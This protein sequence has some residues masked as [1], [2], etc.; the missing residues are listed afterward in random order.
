MPNGRRP[1]ERFRNK[2]FDGVRNTATAE[3]GNPIAKTPRHVQAPV[4]PHRPNADIPGNVQKENIEA[5]ENTP[6]L[7]LSPA[8]LLRRQK[9]CGIEAMLRSA[10]KNMVG[11]Q[12][13]GEQRDRSM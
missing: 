6:N 12:I 4:T 10:Q 11:L 3:V 2:Q 9:G 5:L 1:S 8:A 7:L 13:N